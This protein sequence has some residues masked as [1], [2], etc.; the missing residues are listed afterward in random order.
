MPAHLFALWLLLG[1]VGAYLLLAYSRRRRGAEIR[2]LATALVVAAVIYLGFALLWGS[3]AW[4]GVETLGIVAYGLPAW[5]GLRAKGAVA[6]RRWLA[7]GWGLHPLWD[8]TLHLWGPGRHVVPDWYAVACLS[9][10][11]I[12]AAYLLRRP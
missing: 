12:V 8:L 9:F 4:I 2:I 1:A 11:L 6:G 5:L 7:L 3:A 10:D